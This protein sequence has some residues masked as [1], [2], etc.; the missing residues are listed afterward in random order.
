MSMDTMYGSATVRTRLRPFVNAAIA[1]LPLSLIVAPRVRLPD[2]ADSSVVGVSFSLSLQAGL[3][4]GRVAIFAFLDTGASFGAGAFRFL[5]TAVRVG[6][7]SSL[8]EERLV[9]ELLRS[10]E[11]GTGVL[12][13]GE[14]EGGRVF[15]LG[16]M[17]EIGGVATG[18][19]ER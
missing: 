6:G 2:T 9:R 14:G 8:S 17:F 13:G 3:G 1:S 11:G 4:F 12:S 10:G 19:G 5:V 7:V 18:E 15:G 16:G